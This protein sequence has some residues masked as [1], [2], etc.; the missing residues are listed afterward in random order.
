MRIL[1]LIFVIGI[2]GGAACARK[3]YPLLPPQDVE[4]IT[5]DNEIILVWSKVQN[6]H[7]VSYRIYR[8]DK[9]YGYF[10]LIDEVSTTSYVDHDVVNGVTYYYA[11]SSVDEFGNESDLTS[12]PIFDT[13]RPERRNQRIFAYS[14]SHD[15]MGL[16][17]YLL[18]EFSPV[19]K[20]SGDFYFTYKN[21]SPVIICKPSTYIQDMG[22][23]QDLTDI[24]WA[25]DEGWTMES[26]TLFSGH[27]YVIWTQDN[28]FAHVRLQKITGEYILF[29]VAYQTDP[30]NHELSIGKNNGVIYLKTGR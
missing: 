5:G 1:K 29:D 9:P 14:Y 26:V 13:P 6:P 12:Y 24:N 18:A 19:P 21:G 30:G 7:V 8:N 10:E 16:S 20:D 25:P 17:G 23:T 22:K 28:H 4:S 11:L 27:S 2:I 3:T 15:T